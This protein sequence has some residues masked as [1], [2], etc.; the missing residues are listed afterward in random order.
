LASLTVTVE[1][2][3]TRA[4]DIIGIRRHGVHLRNGDTYTRLAAGFG[5]RTRAHSG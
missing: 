3:M 5:S 1:L 2:V 4:N